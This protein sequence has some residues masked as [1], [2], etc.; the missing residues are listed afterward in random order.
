MYVCKKNT[1]LYHLDERKG[2]L[3]T[4]HIVDKQASTIVYLT[5]L[6]LKRT[7]GGEGDDASEGVAG[8][9]GA[10]GVGDEVE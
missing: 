6:T 4:F 8:V 1:E 7:G 5:D 10:V 3:Y 9:V 2:L